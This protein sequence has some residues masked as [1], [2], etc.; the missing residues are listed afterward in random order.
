MM[1]NV[2]VV[3]EMIQTY[4]GTEEVTYYF[5]DENG[6]VY[7][8]S[9]RSNKAFE[10]FEEGKE[11]YI[12]TKKVSSVYSTFRFSQIRNIENVRFKEI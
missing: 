9:T 7:S 12:S 3:C 2:K 8:W 4:F 6:V 11:Y 5:K 1:K 10:E